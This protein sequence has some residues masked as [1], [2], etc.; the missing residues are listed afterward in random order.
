MIE[1]SYY[2]GQKYSYINGYNMLFL[3]SLVRLFNS[4]RTNRRKISNQYKK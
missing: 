3:S 4:N 1:T 2:D